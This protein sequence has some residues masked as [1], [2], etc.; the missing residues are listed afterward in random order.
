M[1]DRATVR[2]AAPGTASRWPAR[3]P[4][5]TSRAKVGTWVMS[6]L[7]RNPGI[8]REDGRDAR[9]DQRRPVRLRAW[10]RCTSGPARRDRVR[11]AGGRDLRRGS[12]RRSRSS[13]RSS[14][15]AARASRV[16][17]PRRADLLQAAARAAARR[18][19]AHARRQWPEGPARWPSRYA[20]IYSCY[21]EERAAADEVAPRIASSR[22]SARS[23]VA[24]RRRS[25]GRS[26]CGRRPLE[27]AGV[28]PSAVSGSAEQI[29]DA[30]PVDSAT[31]AS[32]RSS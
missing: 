21:I 16:R 1:A 8:D 3:S 32:R 13:C 5:M 29:A 15:A 22:R 14:A 24:I 23:W 27:P 18:D 2:R 11:A 30:R 17:V 4:P 19:A 9:R 25:V 31:R 10:R 12:R 6:A 7:H 26:A 20:D 28:R